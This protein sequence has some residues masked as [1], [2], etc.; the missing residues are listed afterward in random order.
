MVVIITGATHTGKT[1]MAE[2]LVRRT[3]YF[4]LSIDHLKMGLIRSGYTSLTPYDD[5]DLT[6]YLWPIVRE[7][8]KTAIENRQDLIL[9]GCYIPFNWRDDL[10]DTYLSHIRYIC[11][12][13]TPEYI[14]S[15]FGEIVSHASDAEYRMN[16]S[17]LSMDPLINDNLSFAS[18]CRKAGN[19]LLLIDCCWERS[20]SEWLDSF[21]LQLNKIGVSGK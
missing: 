19:D 2:E 7:M 12:S 5:D 13:M 1:R 9:E 20:V 21:L 4:C 18:G 3:G 15:H 17:D 8:V 14:S 6:G 11:L 16:D 10:D